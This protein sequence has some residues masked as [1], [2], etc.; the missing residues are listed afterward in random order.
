MQSA[1]LDIEEVGQERG[2]ASVIFTAGAIASP[3]QQRDLILQ[4][5]SACH[6]SLEGRT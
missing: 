4:S 6:A 2:S 1:E 5:V 3:G